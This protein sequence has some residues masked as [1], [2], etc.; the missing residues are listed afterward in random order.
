MSGCPLEQAA[1]DTGVAEGPQILVAEGPQLP[2]Y[3]VSVPVDIYR[4][5]N[6]LLSAG[7]VALHIHGIEGITTTTL[8]LCQEKT[9]RYRQ[10]K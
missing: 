5:C 8:P 6:S 9:S 4:Y 7:Q 2:K 10:V 3:T 1:P